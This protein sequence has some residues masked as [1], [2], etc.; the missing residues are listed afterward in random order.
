MEIERATGRSV[1]LLNDLSAAAWHYV[2]VSPADR[3]MVVTVSSG[4]GSKLCDRQ[5]AAKVLDQPAYA[6]EIGHYVVDDRVDA[7]MCDC[8][9]RGHL[10]AIASGRGVE[11]AVQRHARED[12]LGFRAS[13]LGSM[14][15]EAEQIRN[16]EHVV[17]A[18]LAGD[19]WV[20]SIIQQNT[21]PLSRTLLGVFMA[22][23]LERIYL[24]GGFAQ[25]LGE[26]YLHIVRTQLTEMNRY[27]VARD[28]IAAAVQLAERDDEVCLEGCAAFVRNSALFAGEVAHTA[29]SRPVKLP[30]DARL[31]FRVTDGVSS[32]AP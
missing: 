27:A 31:S 6:G 8:G 7:P 3:F 2:D 9:G 12:L 20:L 14:G 10:G 16:E 4:I 19:E 1:V 17:P 11:R 32:R 29:S 5:H 28:A 23:G 26:R 15:V 21:R 25:A 30:S 24:I 18:A 22:A 13:L